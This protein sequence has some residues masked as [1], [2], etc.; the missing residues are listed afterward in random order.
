MKLNKIA[1]VFAMSGIS[2]TLV[3][4]DAQDTIKQDTVER[5]S[6]TG[7][8]IKRTNYEGDLP[9]TVIS[10]ADID[11]AGITSAEQLM[12]QLNIASNSNDNLASNAGIT[13]ELQFYNSQLKVLM[14]G[15]AGLFSRAEDLAV[16]AQLLLNGGGYG[17]HQLFSELTLET[18]IQPTKLNSHFALG[19]RRAGR[20]ANNWHFGPYASAR[21]FGHT[22]WTGTST[23]IDPEHDLAIILL[24]N[25]R[26]SPI[27]GDDEAFDFAAKTFETGKYGSIISL[28]YESILH[29]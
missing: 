16:L 14:S 1:L 11:A 21:A 27:V 7:S 8:S 9:L 4:Q 26:H 24:T 25:M 15:H 17:Q 19:W 18:F 22:G 10:K 20:G 5:I 3:A 23:V 29:R 28:I 12:L 13:L 6:V 2:G